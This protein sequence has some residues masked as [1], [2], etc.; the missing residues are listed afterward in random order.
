LLPLYDALRKRVKQGVPVETLDLRMCGTHPDGRA[1]DWL[2]S[3]HEFVVDVMHPEQTSG[4]R[5]HFTWTT[6]VIL[7]SYPCRQAFTSI[8]DLTYQ[9]YQT[10]KPPS[11]GNKWNLCGTP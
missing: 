8:C 2:Q 10:P 11:Q 3:L 6:N 7:I 1:E 9:I 5:V 4:V